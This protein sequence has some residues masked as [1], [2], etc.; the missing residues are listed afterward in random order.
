MLTKRLTLNE[1]YNFCLNHNFDLPVLNQNYINSKTKLK[2][3]CKKHG[4]YLQLWTSHKHGSTGCKKCQSEYMSK[5]N[6]SKWSD[7]IDKCKQNNLDLPINKTE[8]I[9]NSIAITF[10]CNI[11]NVLYK[12]SLGSHLTGSQGC[13]YCIL[14]K[15]NNNIIKRRKYKNIYDVEKFCKRNNLD[16]P[17]L[18]QDYK[19]GSTNM[20]WI[21]SKHNIKYVQRFDKHKLKQTGC[22]QCQDE[23]AINKNINKLKEKCLKNNLD[24]PFKIIGKINNHDYAIFI[25]KKHGQYKQRIDAHLIGQGCMK[26][27]GKYL[28]NSQEYY[29][30]CKNKKIDL[31]IDNY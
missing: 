8:Y 18:N 17:D 13:K 22:K 25:C 1:I 14:N 4:I 21:C 3:I 7:I 29:Q 27:S 28:R 15:K 6:R 16:L 23:K 30:E 26:C 19:N 31:P 5:K 20:I 10:K 2:F 24:L 12:Q 11:H 9:N